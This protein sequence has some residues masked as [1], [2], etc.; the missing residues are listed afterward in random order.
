MDFFYMMN[1][2]QHDDIIIRVIVHDH[3]ALL[4]YR[5]LFRPL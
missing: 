5:N 4:L 1:S 3:K 2:F